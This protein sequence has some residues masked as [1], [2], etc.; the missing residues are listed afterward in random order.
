MRSLKLRISTPDTF[1]V[2]ASFNNI[3]LRLMVGVKFDEKFAIV[4]AG[5]PEAVKK[6]TEI[7]VE[8]KIGDKSASYLSKTIKE[9]FLKAC[10]TDEQKTSIQS[11]PLD[12]IQ[13]SLPGGKGEIKD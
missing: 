3:P 1:L 4:M 9:R 7:N 13:R 5:P 6:H 8:V 10:S 11:L 12:E 2:G